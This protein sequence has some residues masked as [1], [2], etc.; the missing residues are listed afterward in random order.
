MEVET[1]NQ[2]VYK[3]YPDYTSH[4]GIL[5]AWRLRHFSVFHDIPRFELLNPQRDSPGLEVETVLQ[6]VTSLGVSPAHKGI[7]QAW[8]LRLKRV[9]VLRGKH[10][11]PT[12]GFSRLGG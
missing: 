6:Q 7:L 9:D 8:R 2:L 5:Q 11:P 10:I 12:K 4:K 3:S 1:L